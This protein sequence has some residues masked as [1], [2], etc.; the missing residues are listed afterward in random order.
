MRVKELMSAPV[1][2]VAPQTPLKE[3]AALLVDRR[4]SAVPVVDSS[5][6]LVGIVSEADLVSLETGEDPRRHI[7]P[8]HPS[9]RPV[10]QQA[11]EVMTREVVTL[12]E[13]ADAAEAARLMLDRKV[14]RI[15]VVAGDRIVG[16][17]SRRDLLRAMARSDPEILAE[18]EEL[19]QDEILF[20]GRFSA[21]VQ[22]GGVTLAGEGGRS[23]RRLAELVARSV[24]GVLGVRFET[25][26]PV[27]AAG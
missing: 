5:E 3:V 10:P 16:I 25:E 12:P 11:S 13:E 8:P 19:L 22:G 26:A 20:L 27:T 24:P 17:I 6:C 15:P 21:S 4:I 14:K 7:L 23:E 9:T 2:C 1:V 18:V